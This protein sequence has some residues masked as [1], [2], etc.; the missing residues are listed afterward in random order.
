MNLTIPTSDTLSMADFEKLSR[1]IK[2]E[3]GIN[4]K[5]EKKCMLETRIRKRCNKLG[6]TSLKEYC[7]YVL[8][9]EGLQHEIDSFID[10]VTTNKTDFFRE[11]NHFDYLTST[12][13]PFLQKKIPRRKLMVWSSACSIGAEPYTLAMVLEN[14]REVRPLDHLEYEIIATDISME[15]LEKA[16]QGIYPHEDIE[17][18]PSGMRKRYLLKSK[19]RQSNLVRIIP[20]L[21]NKIDFRRLNLTK[22]FRFQPPFDVIFCR[23]VM[24]YFDKQTQFDLVTQMVSNLRPGGYLFMGHSELLDTSTFKGL[25]SCAPSVYQKIK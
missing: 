7:K 10:L 12:V 4:L 2:S 25:A 23:N 5:T 9:K 18:V 19:D 13:L 14:Y 6:M 16:K 20:H 21:R 11:P 1:F 17:P 8:S 22:P 3:L 24:I 15:V